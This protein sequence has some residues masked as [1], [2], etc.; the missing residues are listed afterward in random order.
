MGPTNKPDKS[1]A[2]E[3][4][5]TYGSNWPLWRA[6]LLSYFEY[7]NLAKHV[8]GTADRPP[9][10]PTFSMSHILTDDQETT[11]D[12]AEERLD[13]CIS[14]EGQVKTQI[15]LSVSESL[16]LMLQKQTTAKDTCD[17]LVTE[18]TKKP[19]M[20]LT[21]LQFQLRN[22]K[23]S[24]K[25]DLRQYL[26]KSQDLFAHLKVMGVTV[27]DSEF[28]DI[29]LAALLP[30]YESVMNT[31]T[32][33]HEEVG[34]PIEIDSIIGIL[35]SQYDKRKTQSPSEEEKGFMRTSSNKVHICTNCKKEGHSI[36]PCWSKGAGE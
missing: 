34:K 1:L 23:C 10:P 8:D 5:A 35:K 4:L 12:K 16:A 27:S 36:E 32:T 6:T 13:M 25:D 7:R 19:K 30:S 3:R 24:E 29:I 20:V 18:M 33:S 15:I 17:A 21:S 9:D 14:R 28:L 11:V 26:N 2:V 22:M 31:L